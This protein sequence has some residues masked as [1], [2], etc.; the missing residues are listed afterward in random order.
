[1][2]I[3]LIDEWRQAHT[4]ASVR[5]SAAFAT[6]F[7]LGPTLVSAW[8]ALPDDLKQQLP[9]GWARFI[10]VAG[11]VLVLLARIFTIDKTGDGDVAQ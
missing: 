2:S 8:G 1:M 10:A 3:R 11:F 6:V 7:G 9:Q 4:F 5:V